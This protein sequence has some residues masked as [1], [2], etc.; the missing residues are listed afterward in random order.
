MNPS[1]SPNASIRQLVGK[2][3]N[4]NIVDILAER[5]LTVDDIEN[6]PAILGQDIP[7]I[8]AHELYGA[9]NI[10][11]ASSISVDAGGKIC[12]TVRRAGKQVEAVDIQPVGLP[13]AQYLA[14]KK[15]SPSSHG[16]VISLEDIRL[17][18]E[19]MRSE[20]I[21]QRL[22]LLKKAM[23]GYDPTLFDTKSDGPEDELETGDLVRS[24]P[25]LHGDLS[26]N[27]YA[28]G[29]VY[30]TDITGGWLSRWNQTTHSLE[31]AD[32]VLAQLDYDNRV[33][34]TAANTA[35]LKRISEEQAKLHGNDYN[36][37][38]ATEKKT[39]STNP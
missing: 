27:I 35:R 25:G 24:K 19:R 13:T 32:C 4:T 15:D 22:A 28:V 8:G 34:F 14:I 1:L 39:F 7:V 6:A 29:Y 11:S 5:L 38:F 36:V 30:D 10:F 18:Y 2:G 9:E 21:G 12:A 20:Q 23:L 37:A 31:L 26:L 17:R 16:W 3:Y 33:V